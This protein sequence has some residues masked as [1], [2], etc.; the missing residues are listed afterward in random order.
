MDFTIYVKE[1]G[2]IRRRRYCGRD[3]Q[4]VEDELTAKGG[5]IID[6][7]RLRGGGDGVRISGR[8]LLQFFSKM[9]ICCKIGMPIV[10]AIRLCAEVTPCR[11]FRK[12][13]MEIHSKVA[14]GREVSECM[15]RYPNVFS[16]IVCRLMEAGSVSGTLA[17]SCDKI[18]YMLNVEIG[19][20]RKIMAALYYPA[21]VMAALCVAAYIIVS[22]T[23]PAFL[24]LFEGS[25]VPLPLPTRMLMAIS[26]AVS[27]HAYLSAAAVIGALAALFSLPKLYSKSLAVQRLVLNIPAFSSLVVYSQRLSMCSALCTIL[28]S[29]VPILKALRMTRNSLSNGEFKK[30]VSSAIVSVYS[31][32]GMSRGFAKHPKALGGDIIKSVE[33]GEST[34]TLNEVLEDLRGDFE[35]NLEYQIQIF[36]ESINPLITVVI[37]LAVLFILLALFL[38]MFSM[39]QAI[40]A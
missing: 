13:L 14:M 10:E 38:P 25:G 3:E 12:I 6:I 40:S 9:R 28:G 20:K 36:K 7:R 26:D 29:G 39:S 11:R 37:A 4:T 30:A 21:L 23:I 17:Q 34:G 18:F 19:A 16:P 22:R 15:W 27:S 24:S 2:K 31:G 5:E 33:F 8:H 1:D 35:A 32:K